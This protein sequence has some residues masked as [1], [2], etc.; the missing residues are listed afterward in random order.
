MIFNQMSYESPALYLIFQAY[1]QEKDFFKLESAA[2]Q[3]IVW[4]EDYKKFITNV[5]GFYNNMANYQTLGKSKFIPEMNPEVF[6]KILFFN[7]LYHKHGAFYS[8][9]LDEL[10]PYVETEIFSIEKPTTMLNLPS[11]GG[12]TA[13]FSRN[14][15]KEDLILVK[16][17]LVD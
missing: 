1:F 14:I 5:G 9:V 16:E 11:A 17:F 10:L 2:I 3:A 12:V 13:Y 15:T 6:K 8:Q 7:P 4:E